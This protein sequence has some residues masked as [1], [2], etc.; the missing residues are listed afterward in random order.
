MSVHEEIRQ[1]TPY[2]AT[3]KWNGEGRRSGDLQDVVTLALFQV[4]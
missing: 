2:L 3:L 1:R 4:P